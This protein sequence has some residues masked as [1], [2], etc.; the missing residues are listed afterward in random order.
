MRKPTMRSALALVEIVGKLYNAD[1]TIAAPVF[2]PGRGSIS[3][4]A[5]LKRRRR[6]KGL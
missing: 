4:M 3:I 6:G 2:T 1:G 5:A